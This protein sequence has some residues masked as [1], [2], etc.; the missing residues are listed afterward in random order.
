MGDRPVGKNFEL[1]PFFG[2]LA[3]FDTTAFRIGKIC[4]SEIFCIFSYKTG[5]FDYKMTF[6]KLSTDQEIMNQL[7]QYTSLLEQYLKKHPEQWYNFFHFWSE[8]PSSAEIYASPIVN[9]SAS[10][11]YTNTAS[12]PNIDTASQ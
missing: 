8:I 7:T 5:P 6:E 11:P 12:Q 2:K 1:I 3:L 9:D 10:Q 4:K